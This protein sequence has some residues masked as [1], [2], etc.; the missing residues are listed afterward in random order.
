EKKILELIERYSHIELWISIDAAKKETYE[1]VRRGG[2]WETL[3]KNL[4]I[5]KKYRREK[6]LHF[7]RFNFIVTAKSYAE[8][9]DFVNMAKHFA[10]DSVLFQRVEHVG[11]MSDEEYELI[12]IFDSNGNIKKDYVHILDEPILLDPIVNKHNNIGVGN[13]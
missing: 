12:S 11:V 6:K 3:L 7:V 5:V 2:T 10:A 9:K 4:E 13:E 1:E 8:M